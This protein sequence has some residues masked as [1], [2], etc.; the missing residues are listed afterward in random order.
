MPIQNS[1]KT[2][3]SNSILLYITFLL[4]WLVWSCV[5][6][7]ICYVVIVSTTNPPQ[8]FWSQSYTSTIIL[9]LVVA[10]VISYLNVH[11][12]KKTRKKAD[13]FDEHK[14]AFNEKEQG[15]KD[16]LLLYFIRSFFLVLVLLG[17]FD[18]SYLS[19]LLP[20]PELNSRV[21]IM[22]ICCGILIAFIFTLLWFR[23]MMQ[24]KQKKLAHL[25]QL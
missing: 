19:H 20:D 13:D 4:L 23:R 14:G 16:N 8:N 9:E 5:A 18:F 22:S 6:A 2:K 11:N 25:E 17:I 12:K 10:A 3:F 15:K 21:V 24:K 1:R 7:G